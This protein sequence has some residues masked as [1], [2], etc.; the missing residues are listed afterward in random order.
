ME[1]LY[2]RN[3]YI[4]STCIKKQVYNFN[5]ETFKKKFELN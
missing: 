2:P 1:K 4:A 5:F 3:T